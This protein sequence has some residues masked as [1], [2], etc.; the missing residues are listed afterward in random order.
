MKESKMLK[1]KAVFE[2]TYTG[3]NSVQRSP[4]CPMEAGCEEFDVSFVA[5]NPLWTSKPV[6]R[7]RWFTD[8]RTDFVYGQGLYISAFVTENG[9]LQRPK[10][11]TE[12]QADSVSGEHCLTC[13]IHPINRKC[14]LCSELYDVPPTS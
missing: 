13:T 10:F 9:T 7:V 5:V 12:A 6:K 2:A 11:L 3:S 14:G 4:L 8:K 1:S